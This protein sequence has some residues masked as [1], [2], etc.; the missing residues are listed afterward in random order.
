MFDSPETRD[1]VSNDLFNIRYPWEELIRN[2]RYLLAVYTFEDG[3]E[4]EKV[5]VKY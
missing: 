2:I 4:T 5:I 1:L 3:V